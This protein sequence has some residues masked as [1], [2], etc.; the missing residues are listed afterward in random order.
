M[1]APGG[2]GVLRRANQ[3]PLEAGPG[4]RGPALVPRGINRE[5]VL[6]RRGS[7]K[8]VLGTGGACPV[9]NHRVSRAHAG[10]EAVIG[11]V[12]LPPSPLAARHWA[13]YEATR[14]AHGMV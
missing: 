2:A 11:T 1:S 9:G 13:L 12:V 6:G 4:M 14:S 8:G 5:F 3:G 10:W 7:R